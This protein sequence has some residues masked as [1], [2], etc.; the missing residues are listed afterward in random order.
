M[1]DFKKNYL[2]KIVPELQKELGIKNKMAVPKLV[3]IIIS[4]GLKEALTDKKIL[5]IVSGQLADISGQKPAVRTAKKSIAAFKLRSGDKI[6]LM[7]TLRGKRMY[8]F[9][10]KLI[11]I[12]LPR[13]RDFYG[14]DEKSFDGHGNYSLGFK[15]QIVFPEIDYSKIDK[16]RGLQITIV[17]SAENDQKG[18]ALF[19]KLGI[20]FKKNE[21]IKS[22]TDKS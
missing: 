7:T 10:E 4:V 2:E 13:V 12:I 20:P 1:S 9:F 15:E 16:I 3:K 5:E 17:T 11:T 18:L 6:G 22:K 21:N 14:V 19:K 8:D